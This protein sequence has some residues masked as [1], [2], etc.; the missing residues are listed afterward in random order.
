MF[1]KSGLI[2]FFLLMFC[3]L[4]FAQKVVQIDTALQE[5]IFNTSEVDVFEDP[6]GKL[7]IAEISSPAYAARFKKNTRHY[8]K[9]TNRGSYYWLRIK[10]NYRQSV[11]TKAIIEF[12]DQ[13]TDDI[14]AYLPDKSGQYVKK[15]AGSKYLFTER[16]FHHKNFE[17]V[18]PNS[19]K[20]EFTYYFRVRSNLDINI[21][22]VY[23]TIE[24]FVRYGLSEYFSYGLFYGMI[25]IF[26]F[27]NLLM[28]IAVKRRQYLFYVLYIISIGIY[29]MSVD[30]IAFQF[31]WP[32]TPAL[33]DYV[34]GIALYCMSLFALIF[35]KYLL[36][37]KSKAPLLNKIIDTTIIIR[38]AFFFYCLA[39]RPEW[40]IYKFIDF[41]PLMVA[42]ITG[43]VIWKNGYR[44]ARFFVIGYTFL[45]VGFIIKVLFYLGYTK[46][47]PGYITYYSLSYCFIIEIVSLSF[48]IG[49]QV[50]LLKKKKEAASRQIIKQMQ[51]NAELKDSINRDLETKVQERT[52]ELM[53]KSDELAGKSVIIEKQNEELLNKNKLLEDQ[54]FEIARINA[55]LEKDNIYLKTSIEK[56]TDERVLSTDMDFEEFSQKYP[57]RDSCY[58]FLASLKWEDD[59]FGCTKCDS[60][61]YCNGRIPYN[62]RCTK[63]GYEESVLH[64]TIFE[65]NRIPINKAFYLVYLMYNH[66]GNISSH[67]LSEKLNIRQGTCWTYANRIK[68]ILGERKK[69]TRKMGNAGWS[70]LVLLKE[71]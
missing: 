34:Y 62:R 25:L 26:S 2:V 32:N 9:N 29:E 38:T 7:G 1:R 57:D 68:K 47:L 10:V 41:V 51:V 21:I 14:N 46:H 56:V 22:I 20:G 58:K 44:P 13:T 15:Q 37:V 52:H 36:H 49:D 48:A 30:G 31:L 64:N 50:R 39:F 71:Q 60:T 66:K 55:L 5:H 53:E 67:K 70:K 24:R 18:I 59:K 54:A 11:T 43:I 28:Y 6:A 19:E 69:D 45:T 4:A 61:H 33:N 65:N 40:F 27:H 8:P 63:C 17:F 42:Y 3:R 23:R 35:T 16:L 12:Y